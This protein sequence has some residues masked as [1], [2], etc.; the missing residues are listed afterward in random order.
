MTPKRILAFVIEKAPWLA[1]VTERLRRVP[2]RFVILGAV[3]LA[4]VVAGAIVFGDSGASGH[5]YL[6]AKIQL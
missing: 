2:R 3:G 1:P 5:R 4:A 6:T